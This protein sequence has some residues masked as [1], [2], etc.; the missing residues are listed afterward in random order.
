MEDDYAV[1]GLKQNCKT[2]TLEK[3]FRE[4]KKQYKGDETNTKI[5]YKARTN[6]ELERTNKMIEKEKRD[7]EKMRNENIKCDEESN[8]A[9]T[10]NTTNTHTYNGNTVSLDEIRN[11]P[12]IEGLKMVPGLENIFDDNSSFFQGGSGFNEY[13]RNM[14]G[15]INESHNKD[16]NGI[17]NN[18]FRGSGNS[19][20]ND[21]VTNLSYVMRNGKM[22]KVSDDTTCTS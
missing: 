6:I 7:E 15:A 10:T 11:L 16:D 12:G 18:S 21:I 1:F 20:K 3:R 13:I 9:T 2:T 17:N 8:M 14:M 5:I 19:K 4:M 22:V